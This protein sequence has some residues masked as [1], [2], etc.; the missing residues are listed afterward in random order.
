MDA[1]TKTSRH[2]KIHIGPKSLPELVDAVK[3]A[4]GELTDLASEA[5]GLVWWGGSPG[6]FVKLDHPGLRWVQL[7][8]A[9]VEE[10]VRS[11]VLRPD[12]VYTSA[13]GS[14]AESVA[15][16]ALALM[17]ACVRELHHL[18]RS[19]T[20]T[21]PDVGTLFDSTVGIVGCG[22][23]GRE[24]IRLL[25]PFRTR[26]LAVTRSGT[27]VP[28]ASRTVDPG[29]LDE[30]LS[31]SDFIVIGAPATAE[32]RH[33]IG[34]RELELMPPHCVLVNIARG[35]LIDTEALVEALA[36]GRIA[37]AGLDVTDPEPLPDGHPL[38]TE[39]RALIT[40]HAANP[41][42]MLIPRLAERV[43]ENVGRYARGE[44]L[45]GLIDLSRGY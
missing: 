7:P 40:P 2:P 35:S 18:A 11:G 27:P 26:I 12:V 39:P 28:G 25:A 22:G 23:I 1:M 42:R 45:L 17:L 14:Y 19:D 4:G 13:V 33:L 20:W 21:R 8:S 43:A 16:H 32:T 29:G 41:A 24:L 3:R 30:V 15:E 6:D 5:E 9:G 36:A 10:W 31:A 34:R 44:E 37:G 38:W